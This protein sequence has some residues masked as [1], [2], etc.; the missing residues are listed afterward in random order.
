[1]ASP[2]LAVAPGAG[3]CHAATRDRRSE[4]GALTPPPRASTWLNA[5]MTN[6]RTSAPRE[7]LRKLQED[8]KECPFSKAGKARRQQRHRHPRTTQHEPWWWVA[9]GRALSLSRAVSTLVGT[10]TEAC[11]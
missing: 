9:V 8:P 4:G 10:A 1:M 2:T 5:A 7:K 3:S 6:G 11:Q